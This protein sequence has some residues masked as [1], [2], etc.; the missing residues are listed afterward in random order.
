M[1]D[2]SLEALL[3]ADHQ[4]LAEQLDT[5]AS[6]DKMVM[7]MKRRAWRKSLVVAL[8]TLAGLTLAV[9]QLPGLDDATT[10]RM[11]GL[12]DQL[13]AAAAILIGLVLAAA[14]IGLP[15]VD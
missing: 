14:V 5:T 13:P 15:D 11:G 4:A 9:F 2:K 10:S 6:T 8:A 3:S 12:A 1:T 7:R